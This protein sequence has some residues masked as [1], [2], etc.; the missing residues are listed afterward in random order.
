MT[1]I[2]EQELELQSLDGTTVGAFF[3]RAHQERSKISAIILMTD[4][5]GYKNEE[6][7]D[8]AR[9]LAKHGFTTST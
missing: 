3:V 1:S 6:T 7:R 4:I 5:L 9:L 8:V 2:T